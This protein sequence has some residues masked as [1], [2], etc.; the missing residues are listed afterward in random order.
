MFVCSGTAATVFAASPSKAQ[1]QG[2]FYNLVAACIW[3]W[4]KCKSIL[5]LDPTPPAP[6][7]Q[8]D[9]LAERL[10]GNIT[11]AAKVLTQIGSQRAQNVI[12]GIIL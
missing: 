11:L 12:D 3:E 4:D 2:I 7:T 6:R 5:G 10:G 8:A 9:L 1:V